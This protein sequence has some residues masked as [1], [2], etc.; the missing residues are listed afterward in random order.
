MSHNTPLDQK[1]LSKCVQSEKIKSGYREL[2]LLFYHC[3]S[4]EKTT[5]AIPREYNLIHNK[6]TNSER[7]LCSEEEQFSKRKE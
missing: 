2:V 3:F 6:E 1:G 4:I 7:A 5:A